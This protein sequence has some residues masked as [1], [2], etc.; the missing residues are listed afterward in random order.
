MKLIGVYKITSPSGKVYIGSSNNINNR[1]CSY[2][3]LK[4]YSQRRLYNS[5]LKYGW[6]QHVFEILEICVLDVLLE[7]EY[8]YGTYFKVLDK[9]SGL[10]CRLPKFGDIYRCTSDCTK[11][12]ISQANSRRQLGCKIGHYES[13][14]KK[15]NTEQVL[16]IRKLLVDNKLTQKEIGKIFNVS[17]KIISN[18]ATGKTYTTIGLEVDLKK[19][20]KMYHKLTKEDVLNIKNMINIGRINKDIC[21]IYNVDASSISN[22]RRGNT[23]KG[24]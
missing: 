15:L 3:N 23:H 1:I 21:A 7:K 12:R 13:V 19:S 22:I 17:R 11:E 4:C 20:R 5:L 18:I 9:N 2:K 10:N 14:L 24:I 16:Y 8:M 6:E